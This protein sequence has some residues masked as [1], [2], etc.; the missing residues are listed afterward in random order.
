MKKKNV[1]KIRF[2]TWTLAENIKYI[3][4]LKKYKHE[5]NDSSLRKRNKIYNK[6]SMTIKSRTADQCRG[7]HLKYRKSNGTIDSIISNLSNNIR[8]NKM[9]SELFK[10][11]EQ[12]WEIKVKTRKLK[13][14]EKGQKKIEAHISATKA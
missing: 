1:K 13:I 4:F 14:E 2:G 7:H 10:Q 11:K 12:E 8:E 9:I 5:L 3:T 6:M